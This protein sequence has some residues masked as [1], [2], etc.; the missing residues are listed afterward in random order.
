MKVL[1]YSPVFWPSLGGVEAIT[2]TLASELIGLGADCRVVTETAA[3]QE[4]EYPFAVIRKP[5]VFQRVQLTRWAD[6][7][8]SNSASVAFWPYCDLLG[9]PFMWTHNGYQASTLD[10]LGWEAGAPAPLTPLA[11]FRH[12]WR[13][14][15]PGPALVGG[16]KL[17]LRRH[18]A[19][20]GVVMNIPATRWVGQRLNLP[21]SV[22]AYTPYPNKDFS[23][24]EAG[25]PS[26]E[27]IYVGRL[28]S[29][30]GVDVL[31][32][33]LARLS[34]GEGENG[35]LLRIV[36]DGPQRP[37]L[38]ALAEELGLASA[39]EFTGA[40]AGEHLRQAMATA[41]IAVVP[42][43]WEEPM[44]GVTL[45]LMAA[46]KC[47]VVSERGGHA[48]VCGPAAL[49]FPNG[50][51]AALADVLKTLRDD[52]ALQKQLTQAAPDR[53]RAFDSTALAERYLALYELATRWR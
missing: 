35:A 45:E 10:G 30:K 9:V 20:N 49:T 1:L 6:I 46:G 25:E 11:S 18:V 5:S 31:L 22:Q 3:A 39:V 7:V 2:E 28:V 21:R 32:R 51:A 12:H 29:E 16:A 53:L 52:P 40:L 41:R 4:R 23:A 17:L 47:L 26:V 19:R 27:F 42:S 50:D 8:H 43:T 48:E 13:L 36:G 15:G 14:R 44:G 24:G 34:P 38:Q 33:A 37:H